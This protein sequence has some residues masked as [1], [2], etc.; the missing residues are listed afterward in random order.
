MA[1]A[2]TPT[3]ASG[4]TSSP[5]K[6]G[7]A[8]LAS[9]VPQAA[10]A[11]PAVNP[12]PLRRGSTPGFQKSSSVPQGQSTNVFNQHEQRSGPVPHIS[13]KPGKVI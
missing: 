6:T 5:V 4:N 7:F 10:K 8:N 9:T 1:K 13:M 11:T 12:N 3:V 2:Y